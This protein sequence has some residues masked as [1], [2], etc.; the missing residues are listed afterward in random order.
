MNAIMYCL[1]WV[2]VSYFV[3]VVHILMGFSSSSFSY[4]Q[5][6]N[7]IFSFREKKNSKLKRAKF[8]FVYFGFIHEWNIIPFE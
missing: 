4:H 6:V 2:C 8:R 3:F 1:C 7:V 5:P